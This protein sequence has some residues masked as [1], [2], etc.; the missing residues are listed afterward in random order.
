MLA[1]SR[2]FAEVLGSRLRR[3]HR[4]GGT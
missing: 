2:G 4:R 1:P 3:K